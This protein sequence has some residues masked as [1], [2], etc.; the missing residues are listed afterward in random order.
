[1]RFWNRLLLRLRGGRLDAEL[2]EEIRLH[3]EMLEAEFIR[4]GMT[5]RDAARAASRQFGNTS[6]AA[7]GSRD[8]WTFPRLDAVLND[9]RFACRLMLRH[10]L[11]TCAAAL[12]VAFGV[13]ANTAILSVLETVLLN[14]LG[15]RHTDRVVVARVHIDKLQMRHSTTSGAEFREIQTMLDTFSAAAAMESHAWNYQHGGQAT[16][17]L[18]QAV[19]PDFFSVFGED[20]FLGRFLTPEDR[21][22]VVLSYAMWQ[23]QFGADPSAIGREIVLD[24]RPYHI[25]GVAPAE[26][27]FPADAQA[28][29]PLTL[30]AERLQRRG[31][32]MN[33][34]V[35]ARLRSGV[36]MPQAVARVNRYVAG[37]LASTADLAKV[38]Y[39]IDLDEFAVY[40]AGDLR[41]PLWLLWAAALVVL[42]TGCADVAGLLLTRSA[43]HRRE[44]AI[45]LSVGATRWQ[46]VRQLM[47]E[48]LLLGIVG[49]IAGLAMARL[50]VSLLTRVS[51]PGKQL[52]TMVSLNQ[53][54]LLYGIALAMISGLLFGLVPALQLLRESQTSAMVRSRRRWFQDAFVTAQVAGAFVLVV[55]TAL[56]LRS[57][58]AVQKIQPGFDPQHLTTAFFTRPR[59]DQGFAE[60]LKTVLRTSPGVESVALA[61]PVPFHGGGL[62]SGFFIRNRQPQPGE[63]EW[64]GEA[65]FVSPEYLRTM[66]IP[67]L[68]GRNILQTDMAGSPA[69]CLIDG[70]LAER[71]FPNQDP[72]GQEIAMFNGWARVVGV[73]AVVRA[74][75]LEDGSRPVVYYPLAQAPSF[76]QWAAV[77]RSGLPAANVIREGVRQTNGSVPVF[78]IRTM[79]ERIGES[80]GIWRMLADLLAV[81]GGISLLLAT[82]GLYGVIAQVVSERTQE[83]GIRMTLGAR[84]A[85]IAAQFARQGL[86]AGLLGL[87]VGVIT[88]IYTQRWLTGSLYQVQPLDMGTFGA[89]AAGILILLLAAVWLPSGRASR[90]DPQTALRYE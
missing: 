67:L 6:A 53:R 35:L 44:I 18:G 85:Q 24:E 16:R 58:W 14:P 9:L 39:G 68:R 62:T 32:N 26:F 46:I 37:L 45:R 30:S 8:E 11:L 17:L 64:H 31:M 7:D 71:F 1:M 82:I 72:I 63:P 74:T 66:R 36:A 12:T 57:L 28:W 50:A 10:P 79:E 83:I 21:Q 47:L 51:L 13:G 90:I 84:P 19:T 65:Y 75:T 60:R 41:G 81:F 40:L 86:R 52:L 89:V 59:N 73:A 34:T 15:M 43:S 25:V 88:A 22:S 69:I 3:R 49:G 23:A 56:L 2:N 77:V 55:T 87:G 48:S 70:R 33:L 54:L 78:D 4:D 20:P 5:P 27:P 76:T 38:G 80:L 29:T 61:Y 42:L